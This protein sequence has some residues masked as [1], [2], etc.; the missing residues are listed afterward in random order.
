MNFVFCLSLVNNV[1]R[2]Q[3]PRPSII[4]DRLYVISK[5]FLSVRLR[6]I[7]HETS[8]LA[9]SE[10]TVGLYSQVNELFV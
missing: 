5:E 2:K 9:R 6:R 10:K 1:A 3:L 7:S 4:L 8:L